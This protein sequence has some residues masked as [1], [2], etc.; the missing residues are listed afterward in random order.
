MVS[1][2][3]RGL[4]EVC[5]AVPVGSIS[6]TLWYPGSLP[7]LNELIAARMRRATK[8]GKRKK[9]WNAYSEVKRQAEQNI[10]LAILRC[11]LRPVS[12]GVFHYHFACFALRRDPSNLAA[13]AI[14]LIE[15]SLVGA[16]I[17]PNDGPKQVLGIVQTFSLDRER[18]GI[19]VTIYS[20]SGT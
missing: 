17:L 18:P 20:P 12:C 15:D 16:G 2:G 6:Q 10:A 1:L 11:K 8:S 14:K 7:G 3:D 19:R 9:W 5:L 4:P 13:G